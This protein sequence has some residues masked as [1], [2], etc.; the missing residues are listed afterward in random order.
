MTTDERLENLVMALEQKRAEM[1][2][3]VKTENTTAMNTQLRE[4]RDLYKVYFMAVRKE[5][6]HAL[7][8]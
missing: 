4:L 5:R 3:S 7:K 1:A 2:V 6:K 8:P